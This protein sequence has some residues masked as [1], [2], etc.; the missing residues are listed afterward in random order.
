MRFIGY[1]GLKPKG[2]S[3]SK[4]HLWRLINAGKFPVPVKGLGA[5]DVWDEAKIDAYVEN[6]IRESTA[7]R[8]VLGAEAAAAD[9]QAAAV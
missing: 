3:Y 9:R 5:A 6:R 8:R 2:I 1:D 7:A 4:A